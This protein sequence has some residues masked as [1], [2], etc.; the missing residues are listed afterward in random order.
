[1]SSINRRLKGLRVENGYTQSEIADA[2]G[3]SLSTYYNKETGKR[4]FSVKEAISISKL[5]NKP[6]EEIFL[7]ER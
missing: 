2:L 4:T 6:I 1:M 3:M 5:F 7:I